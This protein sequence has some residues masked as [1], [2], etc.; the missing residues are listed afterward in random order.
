MPLGDPIDL[1]YGRAQGASSFVHFQ[2]YPGKLLSPLK[3]IL[4]SIQVQNGKVRAGGRALSDQEE[5]SPSSDMM[6]SFDSGQ[7]NWLHLKI[8]SSRLQLCGGEI[9]G[10]FQKRGEQLK[11]NLMCQ[12]SH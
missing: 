10:H 3:K 8:G 7:N 6:N 11:S 1:Q 9:Q 4:W 2:A 5:T 12:E